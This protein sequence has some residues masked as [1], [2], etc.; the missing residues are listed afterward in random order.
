M[1]KKLYM[2]Y[3][4]ANTLEWVYNHTGVIIKVISTYNYI[5]LV[6]IPD[7]MTCTY[8]LVIWHV[9]HIILQ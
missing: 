2:Y 5:V 3:K 9:L 1:Y 4:D 8:K 6:Y 7:D